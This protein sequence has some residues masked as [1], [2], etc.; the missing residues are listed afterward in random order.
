MA[1][2][3]ISFDEGTMIIPD[4]ELPAVAEAAGSVCRAAEEAGVWVTGAGVAHEGAA[5]VDIDG[6]VRDAPPPGTKAV[7]GG[8]VVLDVASR[9]DALD[10]AARFAAACRC[11]QEVRAVF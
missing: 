2:Y 9:E 7:L 6:T 8:F 3:L 10:W 1:M 11:A 5:I 4:D